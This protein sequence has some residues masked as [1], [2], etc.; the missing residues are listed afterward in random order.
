VTAGTTDD[1]AQS[2]V[3]RPSPVVRFGEDQGRR[4]LLV[5]GTVQSAA[6][7]AAEGY[8]SAMVPDRRPRRAL[9][10]GL[11]AG[12]V[13]R[14][15][16][17]RFGPLPV[18]GVDD[19]PA[20]IAVARRELADLPCLEI[21]EADAFRY[22]ATTAER[23]D[24]GCVDLYRGAQLQAGIVGRPFLR[25]LRELLAPRGHA[26]INLFAD[27]RT[28]TRIHR[29]GRVFRVLRTVAVGKNVVVWCR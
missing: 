13:A 8:W 19:D 4:V 1:K 25:R 18:V 7:I 27:R 11:G 15:L 26:A 5:D 22:V 21:V 24:L 16:H 9:L 3:H 6:D 10:L 12:T 17:A 20:V 29:L 28:M 14:R 23:F 2:V